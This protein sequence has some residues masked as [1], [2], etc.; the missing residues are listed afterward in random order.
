MNVV[1]VATIFTT[2]SLLGEQILN[3]AGEVLGLI[4]EMMMDVKAGKL[5]YAILSLNSTNKFLAVPWDAMFFDAVRKKLILKI[6]VHKMKIAPTFDDQH[7]PNM[8]DEAW[9]DK[10]HTYFGTHMKRAN[11]MHSAM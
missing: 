1:S 11:S 9:A 3:E 2:D 7:W 4:A 10:V 6:S 8:Q 5:C